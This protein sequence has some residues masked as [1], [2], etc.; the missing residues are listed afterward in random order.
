MIAYF[1]V[2]V[3]GMLSAHAITNPSSSLS[4]IKNL[5]FF[6]LTSANESTLPP[7][8]STVEGNG[9]WYCT[10]IQPWNQPPMVQDDCQGV[11]EYFYYE[12]MT[13]GGTKSMEF[14]SPGA[15]K[16]THFK[17]Q[18]TPRKYIFGKRPHTPSSPHFHV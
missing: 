14:M 7:S 17:L 1:L 16:T 5:S 6:D 2:L 13:D 3:K 12:T 15:A 11:L 10:P 18:T 4:L 9:W 8:Q